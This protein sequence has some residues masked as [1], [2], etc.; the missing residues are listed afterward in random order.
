[1]DEKPSI[2][3]LDDEEPVRLSIAFHFE[4]CGFAVRQAGTGEEALEE[5]ELEIPSVV[6]VDLRLPGMDGLEFLRKASAKWP[7]VKYVIYTG[8]Q[9][10][11]IPEELMAIPGVH[12]KIFSKPVWNMSELSDEISKLLQD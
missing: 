11:E 6:L 8:S 7:G 2:L 10:S 3:I 1:M 4:D 5:M 12:G 9:A